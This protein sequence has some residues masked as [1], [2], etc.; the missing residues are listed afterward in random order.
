MKQRISYEIADFDTLDDDTKQEVAWWVADYLETEGYDQYKMLKKTSDE[1]L[2]GMGV[3]ALRGE[4]SAE[5]GKKIGFLGATQPTEDAHGTMAEIGTLFVL[6]EY[7]HN[8]I[9]SALVNAMIKK[10]RG[11]EVTPYAFC[12]ENS[13]PVMERAGLAE[14][15]A[16]DVPASALA[17]C[18]DCSAMKA[19]L[20]RSGQ[21]CDTIVVY[22]PEVAV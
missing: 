22:K 10:L 21:C 2:Q 18:S 1:V 4:D 7:Q 12:N 17:A 9:A 11:V 14:A 20:V 6:D 13:L 16:A 8:G 3:V 15:S 5:P 19:G